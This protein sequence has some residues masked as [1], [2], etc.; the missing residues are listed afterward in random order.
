MEN[1]VHMYSLV[2]LRIMG[3][4]LSL[5]P[6]FVTELLLDSLISPCVPYF[7]S[8]SWTIAE[9]IVALAPALKYVKRDFRSLEAQYSNAIALI[10]DSDALHRYQNLI[11]YSNGR[12]PW[13]KLTLLGRYQQLTDE[14]GAWRNHEAKVCNHVFPEWKQIPEL[15]DLF[16]HAYFPTQVK[17]DAGNIAAIAA[18]HHRFC[19]LHPFSEGNGRM[20]RLVTGWQ[21][22][23][24]G[25]DPDKFCLS[26]EL[27]EA[28]EEYFRYLSLA[29]LKRKLNI[30]GSGH[31]SQRALNH[32]AEWF[33]RRLKAAIEQAI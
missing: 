20:A 24:I 3:V 33:L 11:A 28:K 17:L 25:I 7:S 5:A 22:Q 23:R 27:L 18:A 8:R 14:L 13:T 19:F 31:L 32:W 16:V 12:E 26:R 4:E 30:D 1:P 9:Q 29:D 6:I 21:L 2:S 10:F 15:M